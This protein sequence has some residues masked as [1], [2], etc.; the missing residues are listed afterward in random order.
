M[1]PTLPIEQTVE[2]LFRHEWGKLVSA[3]TKVF[4]VHNLQLAEDVV[5]DTLLAALN[6]WKIKGLPDN[7]TAWLFTAARN[8]AIDVLRNQQK[9]QE[10]AKQITPLLQSEYTLVPVIH[11]LISTSAIDDDRLR[12]MFVCCHPSLSTEAQVTL[13]LKTL[14]GFSVAEIAKAFVANYDTIEKRLYRARQSF[15]DNK[16]EFELPPQQE[17]EERLE[18][19]LLS[20]YL[21]FNEGYN[22]TNHEE[23]IRRDMMQEAMRLCELICRN[24]SVPHENAHALMAL[25]CFTASR[26]E[27]RLDKNGNV[28]LLKQQDRSKWNRALIENGIYHLEESAAGD[29]MSKYHIEAGIAYEHAVARD[30]AHTNWNHILNCYNLLYNYY[31]SPIIALNRAIVISELEGPS[32]GIDTIEAIP[33]LASLKNYYLLPATLGELHWQLKEYD[34]ARDY[35]KQASQLTQNAI[36]K[37]LLQQK[38]HQEMN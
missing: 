33:D 1:Q 17:L 18:N 7:P 15:R 3:L 12:M 29:H 38:M 16:V 19:V 5:Q 20:I 23:L 22:S 2:H 34:K 11:E 27:A 35:F 10:Y 32:K 14:C 30:Y 9:G 4:G 37:K 21:L 25:M 31:P 28:L 26:N 8:K 24:P 6:T 36:E 13:I